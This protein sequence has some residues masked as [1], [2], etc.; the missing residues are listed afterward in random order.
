MTGKQKGFFYVILGSML[1]GAS[2]TAAQF[3]FQENDVSTQWV[4]GARLLTAGLLLMIWTL[5]KTPDQIK[6]LLKNKKDFIRLLLFG[7]C[8]VLPAQFTYFMSIRYGNAPTATVLQFLS[9][10]FILFYLSLK[11][12]ELPRKI[13]TFSVFLSLLGTF[14]LVTQGKLGQ[15]ALAP[16]AVIWGVLAGVSAASYTLLPRDLLKKYDVGLVTGGAMFL[17]GVAFLPL[18]I[19]TPIPAIT[20]NGWLTLAYIIVG[21]TMFSFLF[22]TKSLNYLEPTVTSMLSSFEP[23]TA[24]VLAMVLLGTKFSIIEALGATMILSTTFIQAISARMAQKKW[25]VKK[26]ED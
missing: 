26:L 19:S 5:V 22:Y 7:F 10:L 4:V 21:G 2:G 9:P 23:L 13:E 25:N 11:N 17:T 14:L 16:A 8:G 1:W 3:F 12:K 18:M 24:T 15:L 20:V 6:E